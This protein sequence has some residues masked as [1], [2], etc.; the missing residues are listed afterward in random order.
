M[1]LKKILVGIDGLKAMGNLDIEINN[2]SQDSNNIGQNDLFVA[3]KG[4]KVDGHKYLP[5]AISKGAKAILIN[6]SKYC[7]YNCT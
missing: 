4:F 6:E 1:I 2:I 7:N 3:I 5:Q